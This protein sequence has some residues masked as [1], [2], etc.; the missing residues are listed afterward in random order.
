MAIRAVVFDIGGVL[1]VTPDPQM[2]ELNVRWDAQFGLHPG[3]LDE[4]MARMEHLW[5]A[6]SLGQC[7]EADVERGLCEIVG[8]TQEQVDA[9]MA[10]M[11]KEYVGTLN[12]ELADYFR[13]LRP[14]YPTGIISNSFVGAREREQAL[15]HFSELA[16]PIIYSHEVGIAKPD[17]R[18]YELTCERMGVQ[19]AEMIFLDDAEV[20]VEAARALGIHGVRFRETA[21]AIAAIDAL[22]LAHAS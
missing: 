19:P 5:R 10:A 7:T 4:R 15:Y 1:E 3:E 13:G 9:Y 14:R 21:Q 11:W 8:L 20:C 17:P 16:D 2:R 12:V 6:G 18:I 22:L